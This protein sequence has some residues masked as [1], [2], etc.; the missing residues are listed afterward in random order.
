[1]TIEELYNK[2]E[3]W[4]ENTMDFCITG[5]FSWR[6]VYAE[7]ACSLSTSNTTK[8]ENLDM[9]SRLTSEIF[10]GWKGGEYTYNFDD[11]INFECEDGSYSAGDYLRGFLDRNH[12]LIIKH[13]FG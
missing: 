13:I 6:G 4:P 5:V 11:E 1:M 9:L 7:P 2:I 10:M 8:Q 3:S 12:S